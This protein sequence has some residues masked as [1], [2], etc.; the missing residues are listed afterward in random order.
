MKGCMESVMY[1]TVKTDRYKFKLSVFIKKVTITI[2]RNKGE[3][4]SVIKTKTSIL[5]L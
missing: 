1:Y 4:D 2:I 5:A 3:L